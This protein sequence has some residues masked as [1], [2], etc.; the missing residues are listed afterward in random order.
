MYI[1]HQ[2][3]QKWNFTEDTLRR[4]SV[5]IATMQRRL[6]W[7]GLHAQIENIKYYTP[8]IT[9]VK[10]HRKMPLTIH[11]TIPVEIHW[12]SDDP[13]DNSTDK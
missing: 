7:Q 10:F 11:W 1:T 4:S 13:L 8:E 6:T 9:K 3:S 12:K 5:N 2:K